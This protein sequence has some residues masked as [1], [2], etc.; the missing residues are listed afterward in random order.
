MKKKL[1]LLSL[2]WTAAAGVHAADGIMIPA[3]QMA[4]KKS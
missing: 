3:D 4:W 2:C 1:L